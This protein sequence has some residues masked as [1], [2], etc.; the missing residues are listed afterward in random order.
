MHV[1]PDCALDIIWHEPPLK[2]G[3]GSQTSGEEG[4]KTGV[5]ELGGETEEQN[6]RA[7]T[8]IQEVDQP[9]AQVKSGQRGVDAIVSVSD[10]CQ[11]QR[12][13]WTDEPNI[14]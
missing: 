10:D 11:E 13:L 14:I 12:A 1:N 2:H 5:H 8:L 6:R 3:F 4:R 7:L 9:V